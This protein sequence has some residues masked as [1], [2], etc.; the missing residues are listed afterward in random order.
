MFWLQTQAK[1]PLSFY[2]L[3][4]LSSKGLD[5]GGIEWQWQTL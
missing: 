1:L 3:S 5:Q 2:N 4:G